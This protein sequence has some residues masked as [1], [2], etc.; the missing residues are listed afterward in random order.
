MFRG[1]S[2]STISYNIFMITHTKRQFLL[3]IRKLLEF[4]RIGKPPQS[5]PY[6][7]DYSWNIGILKKYRSYC[8]KR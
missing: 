7:C 3:L 5:I 6:F 2:L 1:S 4:L 8:K